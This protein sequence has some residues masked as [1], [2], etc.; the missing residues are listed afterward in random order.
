MTGSDIRIVTID[1]VRGVAVTGILLMNIVSFAMP[2]AAYA[3]PMVYGG[4]TGANWAVWAV[5]YVI[6]DGKFRGLFTMLFGASTVLIAERAATAG[7]SPVRVHLARMFWLG[8]IGMIHAYFIWY[9]DI[10]VLYAVCG[11]IAFAAWRWPPRLLLML[12]VALLIAQLVIG[13]ASHRALTLMQTRA[14]QADATQAVRQEWNDV[15]MQFEVPDT[16]RDEEIIAYRGGYRENLAQRVPTAFFFQT[17]LELLSIPDTIALIMI[18]MALFRLGFFSGSWSI[19]RY[20]MVAVIGYGVAIPPD[21]L[22]LQWLTESGY[23]GVTALAADALHLSLLRPAIALAHA[24]LVVMAIKTG[25]LPNLM[26]RIAAVGRMAISNYVGMSILC[27]TIFY[28]FGFG[29]FGRLERWQLYPLVGLIW[30]ILLLWSKLWLDRY[31]YGP[32]EW[33]WRSL[34]RWERQAFRNP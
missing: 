7:N 34:S 29:L 14:S 1:T 16:M 2:M 10:L 21:W 28:G 23:S 33:L 27:T 13:L 32:L 9:G 20:A 17:Q 25:I 22:L 8:V 30:V 11:A 19:R 6:A 24:S 18:G 26:A 3:D 31:R 12:G 4:A 5:N 15:R